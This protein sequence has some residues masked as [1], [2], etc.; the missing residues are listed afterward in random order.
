MKMNDYYKIAKAA[1]AKYGID[2]EIA[3]QSTAKI[4]GRAMMW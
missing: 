4:V 3:L 1:Y 2:T